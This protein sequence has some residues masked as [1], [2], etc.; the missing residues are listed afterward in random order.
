MIEFIQDIIWNIGGALLTIA[1]LITAITWVISFTINR[2]SGWH[3]KEN[4]SNL[5]YWIRN[6]EKINKII[7][8][9]KKND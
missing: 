5:A 4:R 2:L 3:K 6:K 8:K 7:E 1:L 9:E